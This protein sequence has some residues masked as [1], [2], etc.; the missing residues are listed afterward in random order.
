MPSAEENELSKEVQMII[1]RIYRH[2]QSAIDAA[3]RLLESTRSDVIARIAEG[4]AEFNLSVLRQVERAL[5]MRIDQFKRELQQ[6][7]RADLQ[8][9]FDLG[10]ETVDAPLK[11][12][13]QPLFGVSREVAQVAA[14]YSAKLITNLSAS[15]LEE[16]DGVLRR[17]V[18]GG[19]SPQEA[20]SQIGR[21]L[22]DPS[23]FRSMAA[24]AET[25]VRTEVLRMQA[26][27]AQA[28]MR[29]SAELVKKRGY[30]MQ[31]EWLTSVDKR[32][33]PA[34]LIAMGQIREVDEPFDVGGEKL[35]YPRDPAGSAGNTINCRCVSASLITKAYTIDRDK[36]FTR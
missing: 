29:E 36:K 22:T 25:I 13:T 21:S 1:E 7:M 26:I 11:I 35:L 12:I 2:E 20:I 32:V 23:V 34:H 9:A 27:A 31:K 17:A 5:E 18:L 4:G 6:Q 10:T 15:L 14:E 16:V 19:L 33:R 28:R 3:L 24:R 8:V 30:R